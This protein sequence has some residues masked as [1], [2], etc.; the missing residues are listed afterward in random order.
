[1]KLIEMIIQIR[2]LIC[3]LILRCLIYIAPKNH[4]DGIKLLLL[5]KTYCGRFLEDEK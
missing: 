3:E 4:N 5:I 2:L 1:M